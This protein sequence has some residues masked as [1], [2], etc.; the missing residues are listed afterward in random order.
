[1]GR[2]IIT[3]DDAGALISIDDSIRQL[4]AK[5]VVSR[6]TAFANGPT[7]TAIA[8]GISRSTQI[9][10]HLTLTYGCPLG[11]QYDLAGLLNEYGSYRQ[12]RDFYKND[13]NA[14]VANWCNTCLS[15][16]NPQAVEWELMR[17]FEHFRALTGYDGTD[18]TFH[19]D[20]DDY[21]PM[22][23]SIGSMSLFTRG[24]SGSTRAGRIADVVSRF[25]PDGARQSDANIDAVDRIQ[26]GLRL[27]ECA[28]GL[29]VEVVFHP[30]IKVDTLSHFTVYSSQRL[31][32]HNALL[33]EE[34]SS[35]LRD[36]RRIGNLFEFLKQ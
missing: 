26:T 13:L 30:A 3:A 7:F 25:L 34:V 18:V 27:S 32:E 9:L 29:P 17:Q 16:A 20:I 31:L 24:R 12:P 28:G 11:P 22:E 23:W 14:A 8:Y 10:P 2:I 19:H 35:I 15:A 5:G 1:M 4:L 36:A 6:V 33:S 21:V